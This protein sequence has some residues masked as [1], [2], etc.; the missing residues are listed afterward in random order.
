MKMFSSKL[1]FFPAAMLV[2]LT[3][4]FVSCEKNNNND[5]NDDS[6]AKK[7][8]ANWPNTSKMVAQE[9]IDKYGQPQGVTAEMLTWNNNGPWKKTMVSRDTVLH[10]FPTPHPDLLEQVIDYKVPTGK[11]DDLARYDGSVIVERTK[12]EMS[13]RCD[14]EGANFLAINLAND[15]ATEAKTTEDAR[16]YY[17]QAMKTFKQSG[18]MDPYMQGFK[19]TLPT[20]NTKDPDV[21]TF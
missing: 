5:N 17:T 21:K 2:L 7:I 4:L 15:V 11:F 6:D 10:N 20:G 19:F 16:A 8:I 18:Q 13:A 3:V 1:Y 14:K 12:G 9:M